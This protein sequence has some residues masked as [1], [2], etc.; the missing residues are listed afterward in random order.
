[1][2]FNDNSTGVVF[3]DDVVIN[4]YSENT[5]YDTY[6]KYKN[7]KFYNQVS[8]ETKTSSVKFKQLIENDYVEIVDHNLDFEDDNSVTALKGWTKNGNGSAQII[9]LESKKALKQQQDTHMLAP[10]L[11]FQPTLTKMAM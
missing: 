2:T 9:Y 8:S 5:F 4:Q 6:L 3:F 7:D 10:T 11:K 1:M